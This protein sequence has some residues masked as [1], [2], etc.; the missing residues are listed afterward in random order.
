MLNHNVTNR[1]SLN[2]ENVNKRIGDLNATILFLKEASGNQYKALDIKMGGVSENVSKSLGSIGGFLEDF[3]NR[4]SALFSEQGKKFDYIL[5]GFFG[6]IGINLVM[7]AVLF[8][9]SKSIVR[10]LRE[11]RRRGE[12]RGTGG[13]TYQPPPPPPTS[14]TPPRQQEQEE[15]KIVESPIKN[16]KIKV[17]EVGERL[18]KPYH[19]LTVG[20][21]ELIKALDEFNQGINEIREKKKELKEKGKELSSKI[22]A[23]K[24]EKIEEAEKLLNVAEK[25]EKATSNI[26]ELGGEEK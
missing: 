9:F 2:E 10:G 26:E 5:Y 15:I 3:G 4:L 6:L 21:I 14:I 25:L 20:E 23:I 8:N 18:E 13:Y 16:T 7:I 12:E 11:A 19:E 1:I 22:D 24:K 17:N